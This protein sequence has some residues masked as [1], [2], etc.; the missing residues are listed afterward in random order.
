[1]PPHGMDVA[2]RVLLEM[3]TI[4]V[5]NCTLE[6]I[7]LELTLLGIADAIERLPSRRGHHG[8]NLS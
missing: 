6:G 7:H 3:F 1:M 8:L 4:E 2:I 5:D